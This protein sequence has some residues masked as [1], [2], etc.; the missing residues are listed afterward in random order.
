MPATAPASTFVPARLDAT[1]WDQLE[2]LLKALLDRPVRSAKDLETW[3]LDR[4]EFDAACAETEAHLYIDMT[5]DTESKAKQAA[6][7]SYIETIP[8][9]LKPL[10][11]ELD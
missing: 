8:P 4:S 5:C 7:T 3:L 2:P 10:S 11:F 6:F 9:Q 1:K